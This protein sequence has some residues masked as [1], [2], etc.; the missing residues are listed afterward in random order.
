[1]LFLKK[2]SQIAMTVIKIRPHAWGLESFRGSGRR[3]C[4]SGGKS[5]DQLR[6]EPR[7]FRSGEIRILDPT[8]NVERTIHFTEADRKL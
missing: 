4:F 1:M 2:T 5:G 7:H 8:G 3:A 6:A